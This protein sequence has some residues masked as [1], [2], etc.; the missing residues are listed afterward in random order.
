MTSNP[1]I[2]RT[3]MPGWVM[4]RKQHRRVGCGRVVATSPG[5]TFLEKGDVVAFGD[6]QYVVIPDDDQTDL[7]AIFIHVS[8]VATILSREVPP[9]VDPP[10]HRPED[11]PIWKVVSTLGSESVFVRAHSAAY[12]AQI[13]AMRE[14]G[15]PIR[16]SYIV[17]KTYWDKGGLL[18]A[19]YDSKENHDV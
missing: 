15:Y 11:L 17:Y 10:L 7:P 3:P 13:T 1:Q 18:I 4:V 12:A 16:M 14:P 9:P 2:N 6:C 5:E 8:D 19:D